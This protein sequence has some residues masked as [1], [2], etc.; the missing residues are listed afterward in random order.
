MLLAVSPEAAHLADLGRAHLRLG[1]FDGAVDALRAAVALSRKDPG[2]QLDLARAL[3]ARAERRPL[4]DDALAAVE[5][6]DAAGGEDAAGVLAAGLARLGLPLL[7]HAEG[8]REA[9]RV[10]FGEALARGD[11]ASARDLVAQDP[12]GFRGWLE[13][14]LLPRWAEGRGDLARADQVAALL[15]EATGDRLPEDTMAS[16]RRAGEELAAGLLLYRDGRL[17]VDRF[18]IEAAGKTMEAAR[19]ALAGAGCPLALSAEYSLAVRDYYAED[20]RAASDRLQKL[21]AVAAERGY[22]RL[23]ADCHRTLGLIDAVES[24]ISTALRR[25]GEA[26]ATY[27][28]AGERDA[29]LYTQTLIAECHRLL[30]DPREEWAIRAGMLPSL[31]GMRDPQAAGQILLDGADNAVRVG[32]PRAALRIQEAALEVGG[33]DDPE[34]WV[35][36]ARIERTLGRLADASQDLTRA[37][38]ANAKGQDAALRARTGAEI[39]LAQAELLV[40]SEPQR[41]QALLARAGG[42]FEAAGLEARLP[43]VRLQQARAALA[44]ERDDEAELQ[45][46]QGIQAYERSRSAVEE[47]VSRIGYFDRSQ[48]VFDTMVAFQLDRRKDEDAA[49]RYA[50]R[51]RGGPRQAASPQAIA[52]RLPRGTLILDYVVL[53][54]RLLV[55][56][57]ERQGARL[58]QREAAAQ[59]VARLAAELSDPL[60]EARAERASSALASMLLSPFAEE[61]ARA[62]TVLLVPDKDLHRVPFARL[63]AEGGPYLVERAALASLPR[64]DVAGTPA[65][66]DK[67]PCRVLVTGDPTADVRLS[68]LPGARLEAQAV[69]AA[70]PG[71]ELLL[72]PAAT[73][74]RFMERLTQSD[75]VHFA[76]HGVVRDEEPARSYLALAPSAGEE[77]ALQAAEIERL[78]LP[79]APLVVLSGCETG[80]GPLS[81]SQGALSLAR[82]FLAAGASHVVAS[83]W[84]IDDASSSRFFV[85]FHRKLQEGLCPAAALRATQTAF[86]HHTDPELR[87]PR[88]WAAFTL[89]GPA[90]GRSPKGGSPCPFR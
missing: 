78:R 32:Y 63:R 68:G 81:R 15:R 74:S 12:S 35:W 88:A 23:A 90:G 55:W 64:A 1:D 37:E 75:L 72:G 89:F 49:F 4:S 30:G 5:A 47:G 50:E 57:L 59:D 33:G 66:S 46:L 24:R 38:T 22:V 7:L 77:G 25:Y 39:L 41:A 58:V 61:I 17:Q 52:R 53:P 84:P 54:E 65:R 80:A 70:W 6:A 14:T 51:A 82:P 19:A 2:L 31:S 67:A 26:L 29:A 79:R 28:A 27:R 71:A 85:A 20:R 34:V 83:L 73:E 21:L 13:L 9:E 10:R 45:L 42:Y 18:E 11:A 48:E 56:A 44:L 40:S 87:S 76:G 62:D 16:V 60:D 43:E 86:I 3:L 8:G 36:R 69:A